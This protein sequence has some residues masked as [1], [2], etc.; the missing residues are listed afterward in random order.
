MNKC[1]CEDLLWFAHSLNH[2]DVQLFGAKEWLADEADLEVWSDASQ[3]GLGFW[4]PKHSSAFFGDAVIHDGLSFNIFLNEA[5][6]ILAMIHWSASLH[7]SPHHLAIHTDSSNSF[8]IFN[9]LHASDPYNSVLM[10]AAS[11]W[12]DHGINLQVF[13]IEGKQNMIVDALSRHSFDLV[14]KLV[15]DVSI[16]HFMPLSSPAKPVMGACQE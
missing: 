3:D 7:P 16:C 13:F 2:L 1:I 6:A 15:P 14:C 4:A 11:I 9:S 10:S 8:N 12:I 5:I